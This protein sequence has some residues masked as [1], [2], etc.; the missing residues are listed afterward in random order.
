MTRVT[1]KHIMIMNH[2]LTVYEI[3]PSA[4]SLLSPAVTLLAAVLGPGLE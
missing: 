1:C 3:I 2:I 4:V